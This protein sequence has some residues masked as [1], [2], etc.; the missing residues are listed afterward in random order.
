MALLSFLKDLAG[1][2]AARRAAEVKK[3]WLQSK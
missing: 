2:L 1:K 3:D